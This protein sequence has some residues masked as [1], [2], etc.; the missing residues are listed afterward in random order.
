VTLTFDSAQILTGA[1]WDALLLLNLGTITIDLRRMQVIAFDF[2]LGSAALPMHSASVSEV[3]AQVYQVCH[4]QQISSRLYSDRKSFAD[5]SPGLYFR[6][7][8]FLRQDLSSD[9]RR[10]FINFIINSTTW[11]DS[12]SK[13]HATSDAQAHPPAGIRASGPVAKL[14]TISF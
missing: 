2:A 13:M 5:T 11:E 4:L 1:H 12:A 9:G 3:S 10:I 8:K 7:L 6:D 14:V